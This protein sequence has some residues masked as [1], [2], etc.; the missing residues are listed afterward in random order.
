M[1]VCNFVNIQFRF[2]IMDINKVELAAVSFFSCYVTKMMLFVLILLLSVT[3][4]SPTAAQA[5]MLFDFQMKMAEKD[6]MEAQFKVGEMYETGFG[7]EKDLAEATK[8]ITKAA[9]RG[10][11]T[12]RFKL[13]YWDL[14]KNGMTNSNKINLGSLKAKAKQNNPQAL[15]YLG[16]M[17]SRGVGVKKNTNNAEEWLSKAALAGV[18]EAERELVVVRERQQKLAAK[19]RAAE[20]KQAELKAKQER[21]RQAQVAE[22]KR[23]KAQQQ[24]QKRAEENARAEELARQN[25]EAEA[26]ENASKLANDNAEKARL[27]QTKQAEQSQAKLAAKKEEM[28]KKQAA[29]EA[30]QKA[31]F[32][33]DPCSGKS[34]RFLSTCK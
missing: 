28:M 24:A 1:R 19:H 7:V 6:D 23:I 25:A 3:M 4:F 27:L 32:E 8:W 18:P 13:L 5:D 12:A 33:S 30:K 15:Y 20:K 22:R 14:K 16:K 9:G 17:Y 34:A 26:R 31:S 29:K 11:E 2:H 10:H 21:E